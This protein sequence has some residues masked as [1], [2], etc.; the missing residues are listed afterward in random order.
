LW[1]TGRNKCLPVGG[2]E[3][4]HQRRPQ[5]PGTR[6][7]PDPLASAQLI[8]PKSIVLMRI[9]L[10]STSC[11]QDLLFLSGSRRN[12]AGKGGHLPPR[13]PG[14]GAGRPAAARPRR[15]PRRRRGDGLRPDPH[16]TARRRRRRR[17][18]AWGRRRRL[19]PAGR[20]GGVRRGGV[21]AAAAAAFQLA[22]AGVAVAALDALRRR[23]GPARLIEDRHIHEVPLA[24]PAGQ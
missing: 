10:P 20:A 6:A 11:A 21:P 19:G 4:H 15:R 12:R 23:W 8:Q 5:P 2:S 17:R 22:N 13:L 18:R 9:G 14:R 24:R 3:P 16:G 7:L 1:T